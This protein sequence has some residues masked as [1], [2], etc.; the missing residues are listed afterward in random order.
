MFL[1][2][3]FI[4]H[5]L[6][7]LRLRI[8]MMK[9]CQGWNFNCILT[10]VFKLTT[11]LLYIV[12][13]N[14]MWIKNCVSRLGFLHSIVKSMRNW[15]KFFKRNSKFAILFPLGWM[16]WLFLSDY[17]QVIDFICVGFRTEYNHSIATTLY[18]HLA[19]PCFI[20]LNHNV[21]W[22]I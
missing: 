13:S 18:L 21:D 12:L 20:D 22:I 17:D 15:R 7:E 6:S 5:G 4:A 3:Q 11:V 2:W 10:L 19:S 8:Y 16:L 1:W 9:I 14:S